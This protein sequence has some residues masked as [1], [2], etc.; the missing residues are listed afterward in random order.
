M[1]ESSATATSAFLA[2]MSHEIR[3]PLNAVIGM[4][5]LLLDDDLTGEQRESAEIIRTSGE[6]LLGTIND[7]LDYSKIEAGMVD[8]EDEPF[9]LF[10]CVEDALDVVSG[11]ANAKGL[12]L[13]YFVD[14]GTPNELIGDVTRL[15][16]ILLNYLSNAV[17]FT[18]EGE[19]SVLVSGE[20]ANG[21]VALTL[22]V[23]DT[24]IGITEDQLDGLFEPFHQVDSST[25]RR[26]GG[27]GLG[28]SIAAR[29]AK[30][31]GGRSAWRAPLVRDRRLWRTSCFARPADP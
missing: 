31:M 5:G 30:A 25:T 15:R 1:A 19:F 22:E 21:S 26:F 13:V 4:T 14:E 20:R 7:I 9:D 18:S 10:H 16:Q 6:I 28:L 29:L 3:T 23:R 2:M 17:K 24:G 27:T 8:L 12:D 11:Q